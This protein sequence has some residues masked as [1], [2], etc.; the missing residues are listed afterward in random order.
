MAS[1]YGPPGDPTC[2]LGNINFETCCLPPPRGNENCWE[3]GFTY[4]RCCRRNPHEPVDINKVAEISELGGCELNIFQEFK[5]RAGAWYR[6]YVPNLVLFQ[7][8]GY[9]SRR[10]DSMYRSCAPAALTALLLKLESIYFEEES[11]WAPLYAHYAE[12]HHQAV[13]SGSARLAEYTVTAGRPGPAVHTGSIRTCM[14][15]AGRPLPREEALPKDQKSEKPPGPRGMVFQCSTFRIN[16][17]P[18]DEIA[19]EDVELL[20]QVLPEV[21]EL[22]VL[23]KSNMDLILQLAR[24]MVPVQASKGE[25]LAQEG[26]PDS[27][28]LVVAE[29]DVLL[30]RAEQSKGKA[31]RGSYFG[32]ECLLGNSPH[33]TSAV[34]ESDCRLLRLDRTSFDAVVLS[35]RDEDELDE[36]DEDDEDEDGATCLPGDLVD[37]FILSDSTGE[38]ASASVRTAAQQF[39]YCSGSTCAASRT[40]VFRFIRSESEIRKVIASAKAKKAML[41]YTVMDPKLHEVVVQECAASQVEGIDLWGPLLASL[42]QRF[43]AKRSG[44]FGRHQIVTDEYMTIV[45][46]IEYTRKVDDGVLPNLWDE[47]DIMLELFNIDQQK[48]FALQIKPER[49]QEIR[50]QRMK[51]FNRRNTDY[52]NLNNIKKEV[53]WIKTFYLRRGPKWPIIDTSNAGVAETAARIMEILDRRKGDALA[54]S[55]EQSH[56][57]N[58]WPLVEALKRVNALRAS[59]EPRLEPPVTP[60]LDIVLCYCGRGERIDWLRGFHKLP[61]RNEAGSTSITRDARVRA[62]KWD[63]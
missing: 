38:S 51:Q 11:I 26:Q 7:E 54:A 47:C 55:L 29:G 12:Q 14:H 18:A 24:T 36:E 37:I 31:S 58:G 2:W 33:R 3:G 40:T 45:K 16:R 17:A 15:F 56:H 52:A 22:V 25:V 62:V 27:C 28:M 61:W 23:Q 63:L 46:A 10:F 57:I 6:A 13:A 35:Q 41:V 32:A 49:L 5:E 1:E 39:Q 43:G 60:V 30:E 20:R 19:D 53:S 42:E 59:R 34:A 48:C 44:I 4:E 9:I 21:K 50:T 8:F